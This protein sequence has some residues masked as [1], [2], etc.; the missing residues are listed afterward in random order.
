MAVET[1]HATWMETGQPR[2]ERFGV[3]ASRTAQ[4][5]WLDD[6]YSRPNWHLPL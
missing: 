2:Q 5:I 1:A 6:P 4:H 3:T